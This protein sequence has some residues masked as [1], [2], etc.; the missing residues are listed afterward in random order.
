MTI[1]LWQHK[2][3]G[4]KWAVEVDGNGQVLN[5]CGPLHHSEVGAA[6]AGNV[7]WDAETT[8]DIRNDADSFR[9]R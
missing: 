2:T 8:E 3:S 7:N 5:A 9:T 4:E 6:L 1:Q